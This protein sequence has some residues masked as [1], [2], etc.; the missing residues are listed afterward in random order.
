[1]IWSWKF[2]NAGKILVNYYNYWY[3][4]TGKKLYNRSGPTVTN[5]PQVKTRPQVRVFTSNSYTFLLRIWVE[6]WIE[7]LEYF[8][9]NGTR[10]YYVK[11]LP[12][13]I[14]KRHLFEKKIPTRYINVLI[15]YLYLKGCICL[16]LWHFSYKSAFHYY[17]ICSCTVRYWCLVEVKNHY[18]ELF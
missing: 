4:N 10:S 6:D 1:M 11:H 13:C 18:K 2:T 16:K 5:F 3:W 7:W 8:G 9:D 14:T 17:G 15:Q 12:T